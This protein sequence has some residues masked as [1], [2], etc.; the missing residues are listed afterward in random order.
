MALFHNIQCVRCSS[1]QL[2][3]DTQSIQCERCDT[4]YRILHG[5]SVLFP[6]LIT[7]PISQDLPEE[8]TR[9][10]ATAMDLPNDYDTL[11]KLKSIFSTTY[12]FGD[13]LLDA[14]NNQF[15]D[16]LQNSGINIPESAKFLL[17]TQTPITS[18]A[19]LHQLLYQKI[20][21]K[22][23]IVLD[24]VRASVSVKTEYSSLPPTPRYRWILDYLPRTMSAAKVFTGNARLEN[25]G[26]IPLSSHRAYPIVISYHWRT[27]NGE[28]I[29]FDGHR[30]PFPIE[31]AS[32]R[33]LTIPVKIETPSEPGDYLLELTLVEEGRRWLDEDAKQI[34]IK[35]TKEPIPDLTAHWQKSNQPAANYAEN[36]I[37]GL[38]WLKAQLQQTG[39][40]EFTILEIGGTAHSM[41]FHLPGELY[42]VDIDIHAMQIGALLNQHWNKQVQFIC[43]DAH[44][45]PFPD[46]TFDAII[47]SNALH[48]FPDV[49]QFLQTIARKLRPDGFIAALSEPVGHYYGSN[50]SPDFLQEL[51]KGVNEQSFTLTE[52]A[53]IFRSSGL[54]SEVIADAGSLRAFLRLV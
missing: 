17:K 7:Q 53:D 48:H 27:L 42:N 20:F 12:Q 10:L 24:K 15:L 25:V 33:Q 50:I 4:T 45:L 1:R 16:R 37:A 28:L 34:L 49:R 40:S 26:T 30:T 46:G 43:A 32:G 36:Q 5:V 44:A 41:L 8:V 51:F 31:L 54:T 13:F 6:D 39:K 3:I 21:K 35:V 2:K 9:W 14:E 19:R 23:N 47:L 18:E 11:S 29:T 52:Y 38:N 22:I